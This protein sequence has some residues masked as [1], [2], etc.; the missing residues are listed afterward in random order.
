MPDAQRLPERNSRCNQIFIDFSQSRDLPLHGEAL[1]LHSNGHCSQGNGHFR[2]EMPSAVRAEPSALK[3][4]PA[5]VKETPS[6]VKTEP[7]AV[8]TK[9][10]VFKTKAFAVEHPAPARRLL[11]HSIRE[12][13]APGPETGFSQ[14]ST[15]PALPC[16]HPAMRTEPSPHKKTAV[17]GWGAESV[18]PPRIRPSH[19]QPSTAVRGLD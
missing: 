6:A 10:I 3:T 12:N 17:E 16:R 13:P 8:K 7:S 1:P 18:V 11:S 19:P 5:A 2:T 15:D 9:A 14:C 4:E